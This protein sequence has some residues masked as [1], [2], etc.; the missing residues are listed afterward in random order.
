MHWIEH[1]ALARQ[2]QQPTGRQVLPLHMLTDVNVQSGLLELAH[3]RERHTDSARGWSAKLHACCGPSDWCLHPVSV[4]AFGRPLHAAQGPR[5][6]VRLPDEAMDAGCADAAA[7]FCLPAIWRLA[8]LHRGCRPQARLEGHYHPLALLVHVAGPPGHAGQPRL[9]P[10]QDAALPH[11]TQAK[12]LQRNVQQSP[13]LA[14]GCVP[15]RARPVHHA[16]ASVLASLLHDA[17]IAP[18]W[19][20]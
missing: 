12:S 11:Q 7:R 20:Q 19:C 8:A 1:P 4:C 18:A 17:P 3:T 2:V 5:R 9:V 10:A 13:I 6:P 14:M 15:R 16:Q